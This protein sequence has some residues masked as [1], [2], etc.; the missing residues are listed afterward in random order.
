MIWPVVGSTLVEPSMGGNDLQEMDQ[1]RRHAAAQHAIDH[2]H[3]LVVRDQGRS[4]D[5]LELGEPIQDAGDQFVELK[6][7][8]PDSLT[9]KQ[10]QLFEELAETLKPLPER[11]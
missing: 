7:V 9:K 4:Q 5:G 10:R 8:T 1:H 6:V 3:L 11:P 2:S